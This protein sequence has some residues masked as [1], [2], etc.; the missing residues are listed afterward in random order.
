MSTKS[1]CIVIP[2]YNEA[3]H[4]KRCL[5]AIKKQT[6]PVQ[7]VYVVDNNST[8]DTVKIAQDYSFV[9]VLHEPKQGIVFARNKGFDAATTD[10]IGRIDGD[11]V[12]PPTWVADVLAFY[13]DDQHDNHGF[14][15]GGYFYNIRL[16]KMN[17][18]L[19]GQLSFR[20]NRFITGHYILWGSNMAVPAKIWRDVKDDCCTR[21][22]IHEDMDLA[23]HMHRKGYDITYHET[24]RVG[25]KLKRVWEDRWEQRKH[26]AR[27]PRT[28]RYHRYK[29]WWMGS[30]GNVIL[31][32]V[33]EPYIF[34]SEGLAR[35]FGRPKLP[36]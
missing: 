14:T 9:T 25:V 16:P 35:L 15:G 36:R 31:S 34:S 17:G 27:W 12:L 10:I 30:L 24:L 28:L 29:L 19:Q 13:S 8:D 1:L 3:D 32:I 6:I 21:Q 20:T 4:L 23:I 2:V 33:G 22:D 7:Q 5:D 26:L 11:T 18:W